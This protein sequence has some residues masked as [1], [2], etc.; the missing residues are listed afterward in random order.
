M[1][2]LNVSV[3]FETKGLARLMAFTDIAAYDRIVKRTLP[4]VARAARTKA[5]QEISGRY[6]LKSSRV[7]Q[8]IGGIRM[9][10]GGGE[11]VI[12]FNRKPPTI[13]AYSASF[14]A[15][16]TANTQSSGARGVTSWT[17]YKGERNRSSHVFWRMA[18]GRILPFISSKHGGSNQKYY[19]G[20]RVLYGPSIGSIFAGDSRFGDAIRTAVS[21]RMG[22]AFDVGIA[23]EIKKIA[24]GF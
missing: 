12:P 14:T 16:R 22:E 7:K 21:D 19:N 13:H 6:G 5:G 4:Y 2:S 1:S 11:A 3:S 23:R 24:S 17:I 10:P 9:A 8:D 15:A 20:I 18:N